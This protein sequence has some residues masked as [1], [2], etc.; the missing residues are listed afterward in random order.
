MPINCYCDLKNETKSLLFR[1]SSGQQLKHL[2]HCTCLL[3]SIRSFKMIISLK[4]TCFNHRKQIT[5]KSRRMKTLLKLNSLKELQLI[6]WSSHIYNCK[7]SKDDNKYQIWTEANH[8]QV[9]MDENWGVHGNTPLKVC[10]I[11][12]L[13]SSQVK[14]AKALGPTQNN[15]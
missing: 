5:F 12:L 8:F 10:I 14:L 13:G 6:Q 9:M 4:E 1:I 7:S 11:S 2:E 3:Q 15:K